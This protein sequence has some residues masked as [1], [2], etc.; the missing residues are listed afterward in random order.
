MSMSERKRN[1]TR[2]R[3][4]R[5]KT[6]RGPRRCAYPHTAKRGP[7]GGGEPGR[8][9]G[10]RGGSGGRKENTCAFAYKHTTGPRHSHS[11]I[12]SAGHSLAASYHP[13]PPSLPSSLA[14]LPLRSSPLPAP[15]LVSPTTLCTVH[16]LHSSAALAVAPTPRLSFW[17]LGK[18][19]FPHLWVPLP[20]VCRG[21]IPGR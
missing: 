5:S 20:G 3:S 6:P 2:P 15:P 8:G 10:E 11:S 16:T 13:P 1:S 9:K 4:G 17:R 19:S 12:S 21:C 18:L 7:P 14:S